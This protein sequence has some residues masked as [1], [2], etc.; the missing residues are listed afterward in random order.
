M[1]EYRKL[2]ENEDIE[3]IEKSPNLDLLFEMSARY[4]K[5]NIIKHFMYYSRIG[6]SE[7][8]NAFRNACKYGRREIAKLIYE[9]FIKHNINESACVLI[10]AIQQIIRKGHF[11]MLYDYSEFIKSFSNSINECALDLKKNIEVVKILDSIGSG[12]VCAENLK[13]VIDTCDINT[14][15]YFHKK[16]VVL[17][18]QHLLYA[19]NKNAYE[20][21]NYF[22]ENGLEPTTNFYRRY[23]NL[24][25]NVKV[26]RERYLANMVYYVLIQKIYRPNSQSAERLGIASYNASVKGFLL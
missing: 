1:E 24:R 22:A 23:V 6:Y 15:A 3:S 12:I 2:I 4:G 25:K 9:V 20:I 10:I 18:T 21:V 19:Q 7:H 5:I 8:E 16:G 26:K 11:D 13:Y 14:L 17:D